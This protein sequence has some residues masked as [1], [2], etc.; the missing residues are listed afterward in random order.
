[1][2]QLLVG[3]TSNKKKQKHFFDGLCEAA[4]TWVGRWGPGPDSPPV[5][6]RLL[7]L[8]DLN[9]PLHPLKPLHAVIHKRTDDMAASVTGGELDASERVYRL[10]TILNSPMFPADAYS[11][12]CSSIP[13]VPIDPLEGVWRLVDRR[14]IS[15]AVDRAFICQ[16]SSYNWTEPCFSRFS[17]V[18]HRLA[19]SNVP[20][21]SGPYAIER[22]IMGKLKFPI[23][24][25]RRLACGTKASHEMVIAYDMVGALAACK[26]VFGA[27]DMDVD[28]RLYE[29]DLDSH[30]LSSDV[31]AQEFVPNHGG[32]IFKVY[33]IGKNI[34]V[35]ARSSVK[36]SVNGPEGGYY[37]FDSQ[38]LN[39]VDHFAFDNV[40]GCSKATEAIMPS[41]PLVEDIVERLRDELGLSLIGIDVIYDIA[42]RKYSV[43]DINYFPGYKGVSKAYEWVLDHICQRV[44][45]H[46][47]HGGES[48][49]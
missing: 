49:G 31:I 8:P 47:E 18:I 23:I 35:R 10:C 14:R 12:P 27:V 4:K 3:Y 48:G 33:A 37:Y 25:K 17:S 15:E 21:N 38:R 43:V 28:S 26:N 29:D 1:M 36:H 39:R 16:R 45:E 19:W 34:V 20:L 24:L 11:P 2:K 22:A 42:S 30:N 40:T 13:V 5:H 7:A 46:L 6:I 9:T 44:W 32:V 41:R